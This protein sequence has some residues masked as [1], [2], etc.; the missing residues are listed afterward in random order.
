M[1]STKKQLKETLK[2]EKDFYLSLERKWE[3]M[4]ISGCVKIVDAFVGE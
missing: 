1:I 2:R 3:W 4:L